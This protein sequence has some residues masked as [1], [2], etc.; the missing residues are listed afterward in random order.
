MFLVNA[1][2]EDQTNLHRHARANA[3]EAIALAR[4]RA[5]EFD[6][7]AALDR[8]TNEALKFAKGRAYL[9]DEPETVEGTT[10]LPSVPLDR[11]LFLSML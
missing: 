9:R 7:Q 3:Q 1:H 6:N 8:K 4:A 10:E 2:L 11:E 5:L